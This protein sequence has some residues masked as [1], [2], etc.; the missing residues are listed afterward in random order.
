MKTYKQFI[1][2]SGESRSSRNLA[3]KYY[4]YGRDDAKAGKKFSENPYEA[5]KEKGHLHWATG[6]KSWTA[7]QKGKVNEGKDSP[8]DLGI[9]AAKS[10][11]ALTDNPYSKNSSEYE[12]WSVGFRSAT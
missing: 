5:G 10:G 2:E 8:V 7:E 11:K 9:A 3:H 4:T 12:E 6:H 1:T